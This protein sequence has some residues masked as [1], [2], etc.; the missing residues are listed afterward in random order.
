MQRRQHPDGGVLQL[1]LLLDRC[2]GEPVA[3]E[4]VGHH[5]GR[6]HAVDV[7][8]HK[9]RRAQHVA[10][11]LD[12]THPRDRDVGEF[13]DLSYHFELVVEPVGR[14]D[15]HVLCGGRHPGDEFLFD[16]LPVLLPVSGQDDG[17][18]RHAG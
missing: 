16:R 6:H 4:G 18:R 11:G 3:A 14:E 13:G 12:P 9:E 17:F 7:V 2:V 1:S 8:H 10:G 5:V 15:L